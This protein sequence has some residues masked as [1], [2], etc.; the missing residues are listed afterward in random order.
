M[1]LIDLCDKHRNRNVLFLGLTYEGADA[2]DASRKFVDDLGIH[3][4][5]AYGAGVTV[6]A[7]GVTGLP[8]VL[9]VG[10]DGKVF[11]NHEMGGTVEDA[12]QQALAA[13]S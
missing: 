1:R 7:L 10:A 2:L 13:A 6:D 3:W 4:P 11:W 5:N 8:A 9:V 12:L